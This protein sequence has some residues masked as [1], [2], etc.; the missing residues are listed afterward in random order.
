[1]GYLNYNLEKVASAVEGGMEKKALRLGDLARMG[2]KAVTRGKA[3]HFGK[4]LGQR[5]KAL[6]NKSNIEARSNQFYDAKSKLGDAAYLEQ[7]YGMIG[8]NSRAL[9]RLQNRMIPKNSDAI[10]ELTLAS[11]RNS[12]IKRV[13]ELLSTRNTPIDSVQ[14]SNVVRNL[15]RGWGS[16]AV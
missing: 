6:A 14:L 3:L 15:R 16:A 1:M 4:R 2:S 13:N 11:P 8:P 9:T 12:S 7:G 5:N 10:S